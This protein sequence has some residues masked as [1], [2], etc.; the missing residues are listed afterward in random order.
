ME[1][2]GNEYYLKHGNQ[3]NSRRINLLSSHYLYVKLNTDSLI[4]MQNLHQ[5]NP[6][7]CKAENMFFGVMCGDSNPPQ[8]YYGGRKLIP[9]PEWF[10]IMNKYH[11]PLLK[12]MYKCYYTTGFCTY[13]LVAR[14]IGNSKR[15]IGKPVDITKGCSVIV[16]KKE[17]GSHSREY[18]FKKSNPMD[19]DTLSSIS[20]SPNVLFLTTETTHP[21]LFKDNFQHFIQRINNS[22][23]R[24]NTQLQQLQNPYTTL[25]GSIL[26]VYFECM[27]MRAIQRDIDIRK[28]RI[29]LAISKDNLPFETEKLGQIR[30]LYR[31]IHTHPVTPMTPQFIQAHNFNQQ[32][33]N[34]EPEDPFVNIRQERTTIQHNMSRMVN[35]MDI[36]SRT[37]GK[38]DILQTGLVGTPNFMPTIQNIDLTM[39]EREYELADHAIYGLP[40]PSQ[41]NSKITDESIRMHTQQSKSIFNN[42]KDVLEPWMSIV[43]QQCHEHDWQELFESKTSE[44]ENVLDNLPEENPKLSLQM[45]P[46][47]PVDPRIL[48]LGLAYGSL[49]PELLQKVMIQQFGISLDDLQSSEDNIDDTQQQQQQQ[50]IKG[51]KTL[52]LRKNVNF[53]ENGDGDDNDNDDDDD[54]SVNGGKLRKG[55]NRNEQDANIK[56]RKHDVDSSAPDRNDLI[57]SNQLDTDATMTKKTKTV[58]NDKQQK[59]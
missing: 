8:M 41:G 33:Q 10:D 47:W 38:Y 2:N 3:I 52:P 1:L 53:N 39:K 27:E 34:D 25:C 15:W 11:I 46:N 18:Y 19:I 49:R 56:K 12:F 22:T 13:E 26:N 58:Q 32:P 21:K 17:T 42:I 35:G 14:Q 59:K 23:Y 51:N 16:A 40:P 24:D 5:N 37:M 44:G 20:Y 4:F 7:A 57:D 31:D 54:L 48:R 9:K 50:Q 43:I 45:S 6:I 55:P 36:T 29:Q 30:N 28:T